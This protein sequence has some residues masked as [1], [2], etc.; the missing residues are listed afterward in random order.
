MT[1]RIKCL[2]RAHRSSGVR[3]CTVSGVASTKKEMIRW[4]DDSTDIDMITT[5]S[6]QVVPNPG[7]REPVICQL[8]PGDFGNSVGLRNP[9][10]ETALEEIRQI[11]REGLGKLLNISLSASSAEDFITL[12]RAFDD[13][14]DSL[15]L[16]FSC[17]HAAAGYGAS[18]GSDMCIASSYVRAIRAACPGLKSALIVKLTPNVSDIGAIARAC[19]EAGADG[20]AAINTVGP[21]LY[22]IP[23]TDIPILNNRLG[24]KGGASGA[25]VKETA[26]DCI[27]R[28]RAATG[29]DAIIIGMGG[30][31]DA[32]DVRAMIDQGADIVGLGSVFGTV[33]QQDW[34]EYI[35]TLKAEAVA[36]RNGES[37]ENRA[38]GL[39]IRENRMSYTEHRITKLTA[40]TE[41]MLIMELDGELDCRSGQFAFLFVPGLGEKPFSVAHNRPLTFLVRRRGQFTN[42]LFD[43]KVGDV[44]YT[45]GL[46]GKPL[47]LPEGGDALLIAGGSGVAVL[48]S[49]CRMINSPER[50]DILVGTSVSSTVGCDGKALFEDYFREHAGSYTVVADDGKPGRVLD[51]IA[52]H[53]AG[54]KDLKAYLV[55]PEIFMALA[56]RRLMDCGL[57]EDDIYLSLERS[58]LCG[59]GLCGECSCGGRLTCQWGTFQPYGFIRKNAPELL[60]QR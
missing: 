3:L 31:Q 40:H 15:E 30:V 52:E 11:R 42:A 21:R 45:R 13:Y 34:P 38:A 41:E 19:V 44:V 22:T 8:A 2:V 55:G 6:F 18:I 53:T 48:P 56:A 29:D 33:A 28:I 59:V 39:I 20:I 46:Y 58:T 12:V 37:I 57:D 27:G 35:S 5:K 26:I 9:G 23:G 50:I 7:N 36:L 54:K 49:L 60:E 10:M 17:P 16:N 1:D 32:H 51:S 25:W 43:L 4:F 47:E 24:G 14:A